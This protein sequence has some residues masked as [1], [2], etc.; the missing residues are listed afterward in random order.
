MN[1]HLCLK[2][3]CQELSTE[4][5]EVE[6]TVVE[7]PGGGAGGGGAARHHP[8][9]QGVRARGEG[10]AVLPGGRNMRSSSRRAHGKHRNLYLMGQ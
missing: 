3:A 7:E 1:R 2:S 10:R 4:Q 5:D 9:H 8:L 6:A